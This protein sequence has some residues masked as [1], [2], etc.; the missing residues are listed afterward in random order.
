MKQVNFFSPHYR[1]SQKYDY[2]RYKHL[3]LHFRGGS[4]KISHISK[5]AKEIQGDIR[6]VMEDIEARNKFL[7]GQ[8]K[9]WWNTTSHCD[10]LRKDERLMDEWLG[11]LMEYQHQLKSEKI[12]SK[13]TA[14]KH[15]KEAM[16][17]ISK[18]IEQVQAYHKKYKCW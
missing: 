9:T 1:M 12:K 11:V 15:L 2:V 3:Y 5:K 6:V 14:Q 7:E 17:Y 8:N 18:C 4:D 16:D 13:E 10:V